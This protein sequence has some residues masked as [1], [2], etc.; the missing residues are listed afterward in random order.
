MGNLSRFIP[1]LNLLTS[2]LCWFFFLAQLLRFPPFEED[3]P[4]FFAASGHGPAYGSA[5][6]DK[7]PGKNNLRNCE[8]VT[9]LRI[10]TDS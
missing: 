2:T 8:C 7:S 3:G 9:K 4:R 6:R 10:R 1:Y 5:M